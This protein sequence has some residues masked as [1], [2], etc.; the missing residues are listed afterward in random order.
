MYTTPL[1]PP[2]P[3]TRQPRDASPT[4]ATSQSETVANLVARINDL[5]V[6][7]EALTNAI[8][9]IITT[10]CG[11]ESRGGGN[12]GDVP[13]TV[14]EI[15]IDELNI[16]IREITAV[17]E[18]L[19]SLTAQLEALARSLGATGDE[20]SR[21]QNAKESRPETQ[22]TLLCFQ[23]LEINRRDDAEEYLDSDIRAFAEKVAMFPTGRNNDSK[24]RNEKVAVEGDGG[25]GCGHFCIT[26]PTPALSKAVRG[27]N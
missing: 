26:Q 23:P 1:L 6:E 12:N 18:D 10:T 2:P 16:I 19:K 20:E 11:P 5:T 9:L 17:R 14:Q 7:L 15:L 13:T 27:R 4:P 22:E 3:L 8:D 21:D 25:S 24:D